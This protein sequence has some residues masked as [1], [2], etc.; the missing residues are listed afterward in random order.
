MPRGSEHDELRVH[1]NAARVLAGKFDL[2]VIPRPELSFQRASPPE[3]TVRVNQ[4]DA[5]IDPPV[6][7]IREAYLVPPLAQS[8][9]IDDS[10]LAGEEPCAAIFESEYEAG[11]G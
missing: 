5:V 4:R 2:D 8:R 6:R 10:C 7:Q 3:D 9:G 1:K 11:A